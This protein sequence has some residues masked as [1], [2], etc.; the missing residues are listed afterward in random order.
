M[1]QINCHFEADGDCFIAAFYIVM[2]WSYFK[3][4]PRLVNLFIRIIHLASRL[5]QTERFK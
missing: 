2:I 3:S 1:D 4:Q 5:T